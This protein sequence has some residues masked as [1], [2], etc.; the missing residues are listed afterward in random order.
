MDEQVASPTRVEDLWFSDGTLV[1]QAETKLFRVAGGVLAA[2]FSAFKDMLAIPQPSDQATVDGCPSVSLHDSAQDV[3]F[4]E[5]PPA[6]TTSPIVSGVLRLSTK[7]DIG[8]LRKRALCHLASA[9]PLSL[10]EYDALPSTST[11]SLGDG[12][13]IPVM[14]INLDLEWS[15]AFPIYVIACAAD[16]EEILYGMELI[17]GQPRL[18]LSSSLQLTCLRARTELLALQVHHTC[19]FLYILPVPDCASATQCHTN[20]DIIRRAF[21]DRKHAHP[22]MQIKWIWNEGR[23]CTACHNAVKAEI[24]AG[25]QRQWVFSGV[26]FL[27]LDTEQCNSACFTWYCLGTPTGS[28]ILAKYQQIL[29]DC[30]GEVLSNRQPIEQRVGGGTADLYGTAKVQLRGGTK[31][32]RGSSGSTCLNALQAWQDQLWLAGHPFDS[33]LG[34][35]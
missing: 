25:R 28:V 22:L 21:T 26:F 29:S 19:S 33:G 35:N 32:R 34:D 4:F 5:R 17:P 24:D 3:D 14:A 27:I 9:S 7:Y 13:P 1:I 2:R 6:D 16:P 11:F 12:S 31:L 30:D 20:R 18:L 15:K 8:Y 10:E 23:L